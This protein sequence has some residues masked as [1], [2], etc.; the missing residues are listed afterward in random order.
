MK[1]VKEAKDPEYKT[2]ELDASEWESVKIMKRSDIKPEDIVKKEFKE[3]RRKPLKLQH[4]ILSLVIHKFSNNKCSHLVYCSV[5][6]GEK[7]TEAMVVRLSK[8]KDEDQETP[9]TNEGAS[10]EKGTT[11]TAPEEKPSSPSPSSSQSSKRRMYGSSDMVKQNP[12][13]D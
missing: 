9:E 3:E 13:K 6:K 4:E 1:E 2:I 7:G 5:S 8:D 10:T 11:T 12:R